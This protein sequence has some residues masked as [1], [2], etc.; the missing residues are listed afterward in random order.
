[1]IR[2]YFPKAAGAVFA[3]MLSP[4][5]LLAQGTPTPTP[6]PDTPI[7]LP[8]RSVMVAPTPTPTATPSFTPGPVSDLDQPLA[9][10]SSPIPTP[11]PGA[12]PTP[13]VSPT[14]EP[15]PGVS[16]APTPL[17][18]PT[19]EAA[20]GQPMTLPAESVQALPTPTP[21]PLEQTLSPQALGLPDVLT[22]E[23]AIPSDL[24]SP[25]P[26][27]PT[28]RDD[29]TV[30]ASEETLNKLRQA[31]KGKEPPP[32]DRKLTLEE[33]V[34]VALNNNP[35]VLRAV[36]QI[37]VTQGEL[38]S[39][40]AQALPQLTAT[41]SYQ[42]LEQ[43]LVGPGS[44]PPQNRFWNMQLGVSQLIF[45]S[46]ATISA[47]QG[48]RFV[49]NSSYFQLRR[50]IDDTISNVKINFFQIILNRALIIAQEQSVALLESQLQDQINR[51][52]AG[53]VPRFNVLQAEVALANAIPPLI[54]A[55]NNLRISQFQLVRLLGMN[56]DQ[57]NPAQVPFDVVG[58]LDS[59]FRKIDTDESIRTA[60][61]RNPQLKAQ[62]QDILAQAANVNVQLAGYGPR[63]SVSGG[64]EL[65]NDPVS[66]DITQT[67]EGWFFGLTGSW[68]IFDGFLTAGNVQQAKA[69]LWQSKILY[70][71]TVRSVILTV[72][73]AISNLQEARET[74]D[75]QQASVEQATEALRLSRERLDAGAGTQLDVLNAQVSLLQAQ[76]TLLQA[77]YD[78]IQ[79]LAQYDAAL[80]LD[81]QWEEAFDDPLARPEKRRFIQINAE[82]R[83]QPKLPRAFRNE[84]P[85]SEILENPSIQSTPTPAPT[86]TPR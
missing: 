44:P 45:D 1:M 68:N 38:I 13:G 46:G 84:D 64:Y 5:A 69:R 54:Q 36:E 57:S 17:S 82:D 73:E 61:I 74:I 23:P 79:A 67:L 31:A 12:T 41:S 65:Q 42:L 43:S 34:Q 19:T 59:L 18:L 32:A 16:P 15:S 20:V 47:I 66:R 6:A 80:S 4:G 76:T 14:P 10:P 55:R 85:L 2:I 56:Y 9:P 22:D 77:R 25:I 71:D 30:K 52:E 48:A 63:V 60:L 70:D 8:A 35:D 11:P 51:F 29:N 39:V 24:L 58:D 26:R 75:S 83:P 72:Q 21:D 7:P 53:T 78:Y 27:P 86:P 33:A 81:T 3:L 62:R 28:V 50:V 37:R 49:E 40:R